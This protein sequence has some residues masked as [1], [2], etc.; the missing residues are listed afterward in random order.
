MGSC[1]PTRM[2]KKRKSGMNAV[3]EALSKGQMPVKASTKKPTPIRVM[4][5]LLWRR[6]G[7]KRFGEKNAQNRVKIRKNYAYSAIF[8]YFHY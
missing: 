3:G 5:F 8:L 7:E 6:V 1:E 2:K 4:A